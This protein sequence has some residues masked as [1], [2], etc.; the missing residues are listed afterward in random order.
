MCRPR[1]HFNR[2][3]ACVSKS[4]DYFFYFFFSR[5]ASYKSKNI[6]PPQRQIQLLVSTDDQSCTAPFFKAVHCFETDSYWFFGVKDSTF[7]PAVGFMVQKPRWFEGNISVSGCAFGVFWLSPFLRLWKDISK[8]SFQMIRANKA[9]EEQITKGWLSWTQCVCFTVCLCAYN[10]WVTVK[11]IRG[12]K[13][14]SSWVPKTEWRP[15]KGPFSLL[16][17][18]SLPFMAVQLLCFTLLT[19]AG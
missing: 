8:R 6:W 11:Q 17:L 2:I 13:G 9:D 16:V 1:T 18:S 19:W 12:P 15:L 3:L 14:W 10:M 7:T 5:I 4:V